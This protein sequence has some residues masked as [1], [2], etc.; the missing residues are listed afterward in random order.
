[1]FK[2]RKSLIIG[3]LL[4]VL[5]IPS[6][7]GAAILPDITGH[8]AEDDIRELVGMGAISG[9]P[10]GTY[11]PQN[12]ITRAELSSVLGG[13]LGL[14]GVPGTT[15][16]DTIG[17]WGEG[18]IEA[19]VQE[20]V[21]DTSLYGQNYNPNGAI[22]REEIAMMTVRMLG[23][24][25]GSTDIPFLDKNQIGTGYDIYVAEAYA[26]GIISGY[27]DDSFRPKGTATRAEAAVMAIRALRI[28]GMTEEVPTI[29]SF[30]TDFESIFVGS[31]ATLSWEVS[32]GTA[33][34]IDHNVGSVTPYGSVEVSPAE[35]TTY[36]LTAS[37]NAGIA[38]AE[39]TIEVTPIIM[40]PLLPNGFILPPPSITSFSADKEILPE[41]E[42]AT[43]NWEVK[44]VAK[45]TIE[46]G[47][48]EVSTSGSYSVSPSESTTYTLTAANVSGSV[49]ET[50]K[51]NLARKVVI[52][53]GP[54][55]GMDTYVSM[56]Y[57]NRN[58]G[59]RTWL[60]VGNAK[61]IGHFWLH[62]ALLQ[63][64][65][66]S[67]PDDAVIMS[68]HLSMYQFEDAS[69]E[70]FNVSTHQITTPWDYITVTWNNQPHYNKTSESTR[71]VTPGVTH[72]ISWDIKNL[73]Q[74]WVSGSITNNGLVLKRTNELEGTK[75]NG[76]FRS[77]RYT[78]Q[79]GARPGL[80]ITYYVP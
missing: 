17:H 11:R 38:T 42:T 20:G 73:V 80:D 5:L 43:L 55:E 51:I 59:G 63:F 16:S 14:A 15:F 2:N 4:I 30:S 62:R 19:L 79:P 44:G 58:F 69:D 77:S 52:Q 22:T 7:A 36:K 41:G 75:Y 65:V 37:N 78:D 6:T 31:T 49:S 3:I 64:D 66:S 46:P 54:G 48:G 70:E 45:V 71:P 47:I 1:M 26:Q 67:I 10:D 72:W 76:S 25:T 53:P 12:T 60:S 50:A 40:P 74:G 39:V 28:L 9:Y 27:P 29:V 68:A 18:R 35:T 57:A 32:G 34:A 23:N 8:W 56:Y 21:I 33:I 24:M 61:F 13:A